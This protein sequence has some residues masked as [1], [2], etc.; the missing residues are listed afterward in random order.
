LLSV[1]C[2][3]ISQVYHWV[4]KLIKNA[5]DRYQFGQ[6]FGGVIFPPYSEA[7]GRK[8][9]YISASLLY[10]ISCIIVGVPKSVSSAVI[11]R[12]ISGFMSAVPSIIVSGSI[13]DMYDVNQRVWLMYAWACATTG[14]LLL[15]PV[16][17]SY[18]SAAIGW[19]VYYP[20]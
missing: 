18:I 8:P 1:A 13:E 4:P 7:F 3:S 10:C 19:Y 15:G 5:I 17:G 9:V 16:Y 11:G 20:L 12:F 14:G 2:K 6:A